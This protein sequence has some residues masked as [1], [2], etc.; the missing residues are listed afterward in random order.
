V[1]VDYYREALIV[2]GWKELPLE[3][4]QAASGTAFM[5]GA[6]EHFEILPEDDFYTRNA[7][8]SSGNLTPE[9]LDE[10]SIVFVVRVTRTCGSLS[11]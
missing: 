8:E 10:F 4:D 6:D 2:Q 3:Q 9:E 1:A 11:L 5:R 7:I